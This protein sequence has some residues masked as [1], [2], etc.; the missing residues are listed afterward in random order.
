MNQHDP[1]AQAREVVSRVI[2]DYAN[3]R[4]AYYS[5][6]NLLKKLLAKDHLLFALKGATTA[7][8]WLD[9]ALSAHESSSEETMMGNLW[10]Q[11]LTALSQSVGAGDLLVEKDDFLWVVEMKS[12]KTTLNSS[13]L[14][15][16]L[17]ALK[18]KVLRHARTRT[19]GRRGVKAMIGV[20][21]GAAKDEFKTYPAST[22]ENSDISGFQYQYVV[23]EPFLIWL[24]GMADPAS[25]IA[26]RLEMGQRIAAARAAG[27]G[28][29]LDELRQ[30]LSRR[31]LGDSMA[32]IFAI[33]ASSRGSTDT[34]DR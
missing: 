2:G 6:Q 3:R 18:H 16:T 23:G 19:P 31:G 24:T 5:D 28:R 20:I 25:L 21:R 32:S 34:R 29:L 17:R 4:V 15:Q 8:E 14:A 13:S 10:Q 27:R 33:A 12:Q 1:S 26:D 30:L 7:S 11:I 22:G 9:L